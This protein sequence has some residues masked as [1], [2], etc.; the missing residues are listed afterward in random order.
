MQLYSAIF[1]TFAVFAICGYIRHMRQCWLYSIRADI[2]VIFS[3]MRLYS[4]YA[5]IIFACWDQG[6]PATQNIKKKNN[7][8]EHTHT[9]ECIPP[10]GIA[11]N[12]RHRSE[13]P[14]RTGRLKGEHEVAM[15]K[16]NVNTRCHNMSLHCMQITIESNSL[17]LLFLA[18]GLATSNH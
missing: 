6:G 13:Y 12:I 4:L 7:S 15:W 5:A 17:G 14:P 9:Y 16:Y 11:Q 1:A 18:A 2:F 3:Y 10:A 8:S